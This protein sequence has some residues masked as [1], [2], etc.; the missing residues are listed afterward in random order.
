MVRLIDEWTWDGSDAAT[1][2]WARLECRDQ[3]RPGRR[4]AS[5]R[6]PL[7]R[8]LAPRVCPRD[9]RAHTRRVDRGRRR[10]AF[11]EFVAPDRCLPGAAPDPPRSAVDLPLPWPEL[12]VAARREAE[13]L[14]VAP[15]RLDDIVLAVQEVAT[16][17]ER[18]GTPP[19]GSGSG[20]TAA[21]SSARS[22]KAGAAASIRVPAGSL[23]TIR[24]GAAGPAD[25][26][27]DLRCRRDRPR[28]GRHHRDHV[29]GSR[30]LACRLWSSPAD[31]RAS[32]G[33]VRQLLREPSVP[34]VH[35]PTTPTPASS[36]RRSRAWP[37]ATAGWTARPSESAGIGVRVRVDGAWGFAATRRLD[38]AAAEE[39]LEHALDV[40]RARPA[41]RRRSSSPSSRR[42]TEAGRPRWHRIPSPSRWRRS[43]SG[44]PGRRSAAGREGDSR[45]GRVV[46]GVARA[47]AV[48]LERG[49]AVRAAS[50]RVRQRI[51]AVAVRGDHPRC[52]SFPAS[53]GGRSAPEARALHRPRPRRRP[54]AV[55][56]RR[57]WHCSPLQ[58]ARRDGGP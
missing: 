43:S 8:P 58:P 36:T 46:P 16:N 17:A 31:S 53:R 57:Q 54:G 9:H 50:H 35:A 26:A 18:H 30:V 1:R 33:R 39:A 44:S 49:R 11:A 24:R 20:G 52:A 56:P 12:R 2:E 29:H 15:E 28:P 3:P 55:W 6:E 7:R 27:P 38:R 47:Q 40:A 5:A 22:P 4:G 45:C 23:P 41:R 51:T 10:C 32:L 14:G 25:R 13:R 42:R 34:R 21:S 48:R 37:P 19:V